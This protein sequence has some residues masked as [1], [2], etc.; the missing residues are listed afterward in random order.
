[1]KMSVISQEMDKKFEIIWRWLTFGN[2]FVELSLNAEMYKKKC[3][4]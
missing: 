2:A 3:V 1:L 4:T